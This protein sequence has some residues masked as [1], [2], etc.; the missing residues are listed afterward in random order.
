MSASDCQFVIIRPEVNNDDKRF[1]HFIKF[2]IP[3]DPNEPDG[4]KTII[5]FRKIESDEPEDVL[6]HLRKFD[7]LAHFRLFKLT[8]G[9]DTQ[10]DWAT[11]LEEIGD[12]RGQEEFLE[13]L[14]TF[15]LS[16]A[17]NTKEWLNQV[18]KPIFMTVHKFLQR[19]K[20]INNLFSVM[21][22]PEDGADEDER[23]DGFT[24]AE[25]RNILKKVSPRAWRDTQDNPIFVS[26][27]SPHKASTMKNCA[28]STNATR[29]ALKVRNPVTTSRVARTTIKN[30]FRKS[31]RL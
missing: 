7:K 31:R 23:I 14:D 4:L 18:R 9:P 8:L 16:C 12:N 3:I 11:V 5:Q 25:L 20:Q 27:Q 30:H 28:I 21:P 13:A 1:V 2:E 17:I 15:L 19:V 24:E 6:V 22:L 10:S 26:I 29:I